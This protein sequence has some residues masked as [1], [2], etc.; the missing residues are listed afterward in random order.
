MTAA[1]HVAL[2]VGALYLLV[3]AY[4]AYLHVCK[5]LARRAEARR[6]NKQIRSPR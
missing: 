2:A 3:G 1:W 6:I 5:R 4:V